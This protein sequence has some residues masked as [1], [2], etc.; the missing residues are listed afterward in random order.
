MNDKSESELTEF[1]KASARW[2]PR[3]MDEVS[4]LIEQ[5]RLAARGRSGQY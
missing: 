2:G 1:E 4:K 5:A 3:T